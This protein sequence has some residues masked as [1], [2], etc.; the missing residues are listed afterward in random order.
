M[1]KHFL[2]IGVGSGFI[3]KY[4]TN[5]LT[6]ISGVLIDIN[7]NSIYYNL[8]HFKPEPQLIGNNDFDKVYANDKITLIIGDALKLIDIIKKNNKG[9]DIYDLIV[10]NPPYIPKSHENDVDESITNENVPKNFFEGTYLMR[11]LLKNVELL[12]TKSMLMIVSSTSFCVD[13]VNT[14]LENLTS[15]GFTL[16]ILVEREVPL[17]VYDT[18]TSKWLHENEEWKN[19]LLSNIG[20][21]NVNGIKFK[22]G[23]TLCKNT[24]FHYVYVISISKNINTSLRE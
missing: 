22:K 17:K 1:Y 10:C 5:K 15:K 4:I 8:N 18:D 24:L 11:Y 13:Y 14:D 19:F 21:I 2:E 16:E 6:N 23:C 20:N 12:T 9:E 7:P 3:S